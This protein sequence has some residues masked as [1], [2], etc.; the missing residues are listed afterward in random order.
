MF[1]ELQLFKGEPRYIFNKDGKRTLSEYE[2]KMV[3]HNGSGFD[4]WII[5][6]NLPEW[7][8][9]VNM[10]KTGKGIISLKIHNGNIECKNGSKG[11]PQYITFVCS[12]N[13][14]SSSLKKLR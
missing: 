3:A 7:C 8:S 10:I 14:L 6:Y 12:M 11:K 2:L 5:L 1:K 4:I 9:I 13:H